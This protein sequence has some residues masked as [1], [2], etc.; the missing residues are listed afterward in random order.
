MKIQDLRSPYGRRKARKRKGRGMGSGR[1]KTRGRGSKGQHARSGITRMSA[2]EGGQMPLVRRIPKVGFT[3]KNKI[4]YSIVNLE[5]LARFEQ[6]LNVTPQLLEEK[7]L[8]RNLNRPV[9]I[10]GKGELKKSLNISAHAFSASAKSAI[11]KA[12]G[13]TEIIK[14]TKIKACLPAGRVK[15]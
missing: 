1:G 5:R 10:L 14:D 11:E 15:G 13:K 8:V 4:E 3:S 6:G 2:L 9:K 7:G 12:G